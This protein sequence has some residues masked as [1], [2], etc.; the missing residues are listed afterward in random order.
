[1]RLLLVL[2]FIVFVVDG[3]CGPEA[4]GD[5]P[6]PWGGALCKNDGDCGGIGVGKCVKSTISINST[7]ATINPTDTNDAI[8]TIG[9]SPNT[10]ICQCPVSRGG[11]NC[12]HVRTSVQNGLKYSTPAIASIFCIVVAGIIFILGILC[13][14]SKDGTCSGEIAGW[15]LVMGGVSF[16]GSFIWMTVVLAQLYNCE[17]KDS[18][19]YVMYYK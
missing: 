13:I 8:Y 18:A 17:V 6:T 11:P 2:L 10:T 9:V 7:T 3:M 5:D 19:G 14:C 4:F 12:N 15:P 16:F 1:M